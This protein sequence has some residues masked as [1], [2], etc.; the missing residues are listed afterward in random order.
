[1][2]KYSSDAPKEWW[3]RILNYGRK[4][5]S[6]PDHRVYFV[7]NPEVVFDIT[8]PLGT[9]FRVETSN[10]TVFGEQKVLIGILGELEK[11]IFDLKD[12][13]TKLE[14]YQAASAERIETLLSSIER[15]V[16][17]PS[18]FEIDC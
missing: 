12:R 13:V 17:G 7:P 18:V 11:L 3:D 9:S 2:N 8:L 6:K 5:T 4:K 14:I 10:E 16:S 15:K 1:M